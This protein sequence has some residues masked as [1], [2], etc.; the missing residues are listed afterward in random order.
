M[1]VPKVIGDPADPPSGRF[2]GLASLLSRENAGIVRPLQPG[3][4]WGLSVPA[5]Q[6]ERQ[7]LLKR[8]AKAFSFP[9]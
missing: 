2:P 3:P 5:N 4:L 6:P 1:A 8:S 9:L 7:V